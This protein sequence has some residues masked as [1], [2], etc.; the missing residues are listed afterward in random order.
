MNRVLAASGAPTD[1]WLLVHVAA[2]YATL[3]IV[4]RGRVIFFRHRGAD[5][6]ESLADLVHQ[7]AMYYEDRLSGRGFAPRVP[8]G[9]GRRPR[10]AAGADKARRA[11]AERLNAKVEPLDL[12]GVATLA[13]RI[14]ASPGLV[15]QL[16]P[17][18]G[19]LAGE[20]AA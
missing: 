5:G 4:R 7:T 18:V 20:P 14:S 13:D 6:E 17:L 15:D 16:A 8:R 2:D 12:S 11:L 1:D 10:G 9:R 19:V 3:V